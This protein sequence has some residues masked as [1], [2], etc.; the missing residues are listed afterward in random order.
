V[1]YFVSSDPALIAAHQAESKDEGDLLHCRMEGEFLV[2]YQTAGGWAALTKDLL[3][4][5]L[6]AGR[7]A[8][9]TLPRA[10]AQVL[11]LMCADLAVIQNPIHGELHE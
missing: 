2:S 11:K 3:T 1:R 7:D 5:V 8:R 9:I 6:G 4:D 10:P